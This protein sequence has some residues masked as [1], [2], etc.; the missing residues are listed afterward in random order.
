MVRKYSV[1]AENIEVAGEYR[2]ARLAIHRAGI[3]GRIKSRTGHR[4]P[5]G[6][7]RTVDRNEDAGSSFLS[8]VRQQLKRSLPIDIENKS[9]SRAGVAPNHLLLGQE[10][11]FDKRS[12]NIGRQPA[13]RTSKIADIYRLER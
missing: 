12:S 7:K 5:A 8:T 10:V 2:E 11:R 9:D 1:R 4:G 13:I 6:L 3:S